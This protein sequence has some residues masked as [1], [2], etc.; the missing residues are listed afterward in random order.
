MPAV[1]APRYALLRRSHRFT[2]VQTAP[3]SS[4][5]RIWRN[6]RPD[7]PCDARR[8]HRA[9]QHRLPEGEPAQGRGVEGREGVEGVAL[10]RGAP[11]RRVQERE[12][13]GGVVPDQHRPRAS[14]VAY[15]L[16][17][18]LSTFRNASRSGLAL[19]S[20]WSRT[21]PLNSSAA[22]STL[23]SG[24]GSTWEECTVS[25][26]HR[27]LPVDPEQHHRDLEQGVGG[28]IEPA[29]LDIHHHR[30][31]AAKTARDGRRRPA[32]GAAIRITIRSPARCAG[33]VRLTAR[34]TRP[35]D[36]RRNTPHRS[37]HGA[38]P[39]PP[40]PRPGTA[41]ARRPPSASCPGPSRAS[42]AA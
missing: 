21:I 40:G 20:G 16:A 37:T 42:C 12:V 17:H 14:V 35:P 10:E 3:P 39:Q 23:A 11:D 32:H 6:A 33:T 22:G 7:C 36:F 27:P 18:R 2:M 41:R 15:R 19:R 28:G 9:R 1:L 30:E 4:P 38:M 26:P 34:C 25:I 13:E 24:N 8:L 31:E 29:G 5:R